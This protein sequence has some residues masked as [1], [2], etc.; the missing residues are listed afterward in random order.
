MNQKATNNLGREKNLDDH[1]AN[2]TSQ[3][4]IDSRRSRSLAY[5]IKESLSVSKALT[6]TNW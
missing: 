6:E 2:I 1:E 4:T 3:P 5:K